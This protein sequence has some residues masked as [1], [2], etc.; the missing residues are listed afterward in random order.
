MRISIYI[1]I[2][3][4]IYIYIY[5]K[6]GGYRRLSPDHC[7]IRARRTPRLERR[8]R[9]DRNTLIAE[10]LC[11]VLSA[12]LGLNG[13]CNTGIHRPHCAAAQGQREPVEAFPSR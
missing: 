1:Y 8:V 10:P 13:D 2:Y 5:T 6:K 3:T 9:Y 4:Y 7:R 11:G 12:V